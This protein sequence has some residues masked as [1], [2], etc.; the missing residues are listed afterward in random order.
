[1]SYQDTDY[2]IITSVPVKTGQTTNSST[3]SNKIISETSVKT[4]QTSDSSTCGQSNKIISETSVKTG[5]TSDNFTCYPSNKIITEEA[6]FVSKLEWWCTKCDKT[7][8]GFYLACPHCG[9]LPIWDRIFC[10]KCERAYYEVD[11]KTNRANFNKIL[12]KFN[13]VS[14]EFCHWFNPYAN[15]CPKCNI[16]AKPYQ[17][18]C[19]VCGFVFEHISTRSIKLKCHL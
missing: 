17:E 2:K 1:M 10:P 4:K 3:C 11:E 13:V 14:C 16:S 5:Q 15:E 19:L 8:V 12:N 9:E 18:K 7:I 6:I